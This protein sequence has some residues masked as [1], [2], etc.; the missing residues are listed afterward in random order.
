VGFKQYLLSLTNLT[1]TM[2][3]LTSFLIL[4]F[5][6]VI[7]SCQ[8][9]EVP[10]NNQG[11]IGTWKNADAATSD[12]SYEIIINANGTAEYHEAGVSGA[13]SKQVDIKGYIF[14]TDFDFKIGS[15]HL[16]GKKFTANVPPKRITTSL[17]PYTYSMTA[18][19]NQVVYSKQ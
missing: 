13:T 8:K 16:I 11:Y 10:D 17:K 7:L 12:Y 15:K 3:K 14:F 9:G 5:S 6:F 4:V 18:T 1:P 19:F 2:K